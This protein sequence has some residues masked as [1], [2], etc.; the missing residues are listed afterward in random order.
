MRARAVVLR[1]DA[2]LM[3]KVSIGGRTWWTL[4]GGGVEPGETEE[5][6][7]LRELAEET[8]LQ[9]TNPRLLCHVPDACYLVD[10]DENDEPRLDIDPSLNDATE[11][12]D[13]AWRPLAEVADDAHVKVVIAALDA[14]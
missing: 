10:V 1:G 5:E 11:I 6:A 9:G 8:Q 4:P 14:S 12:V 3:V 7:A 2:V 13:V